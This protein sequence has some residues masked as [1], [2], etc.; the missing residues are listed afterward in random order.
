MDSIAGYP[1]A[2]QGFRLRPPGDSSVADRFHGLLKEGGLAQVQREV[3][4]RPQLLAELLPIVANPEASINVRIGAS[5]IFEAHAGGAALRALRRR[6]GEL[7][8]DAD[9]RV[10]AD[11]CHYLGLS[12]D[13][14]MPADFDGDGKTDIAVYRP[15][16]GRWLIRYAALN[17]DAG[18]EGSFD[19]GANGDVPLTGDVDGD[20]SSDI[21]VFRP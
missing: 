4:A 7:S 3:A 2:P 9:A 20:G 12:G 8:M 15:G 21:T 18:Q 16:T 10:R 1:Y 17:F 5:V 14:P 11:A 19:W 6:L 13:V